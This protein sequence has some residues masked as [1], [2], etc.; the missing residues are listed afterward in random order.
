MQEEMQ[1]TARKEVGEELQKLGNQDL[2]AQKCS[3]NMDSHPSAHTTRILVHIRTVRS[4][5]FFGVCNTVL[6][7]LL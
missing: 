5:I 7:V 3:Y 4:T 1:N 6:S 2:K